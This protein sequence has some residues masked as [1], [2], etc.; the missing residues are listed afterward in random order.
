MTNCKISKCEGQATA[1]GNYPGIC[2]KCAKLVE[3]GYM[4]MVDY[5]T[6][7]KPQWGL[8]RKVCKVYMCQD[9]AICGNGEYSDL[10]TTCAAKMR[11]GF[12]HLVNRGDIHQPRWVIEIRP[13]A[14]NIGV[15]APRNMV[16]A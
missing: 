1:E 10:C 13:V 6:A 8:R 3:S 16:S 14:E 5:G 7:E 15:I 4:E 11:S 9:A 12:R 2:A